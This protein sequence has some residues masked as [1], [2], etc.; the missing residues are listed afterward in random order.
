MRLLLDANLSP[1]TRQH[2]TEAFG[3]DVIDLITER[4]A[5]LSD[6]EVATVAKQENRII[7]TFDRDFGE[8]YYLKE[9]SKI[10]VIVLRLEDQTVESV[11]Q[12]LD[13][14]FSGAARDIDLATS[15]VI[16]EENRARI[17]TA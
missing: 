17:I 14:F 13:A 10:G 11:N 3:F 5:T 1:E 7:V 8:I 6:A 2:L 15:L 4:K 16:L 9:R 12:A